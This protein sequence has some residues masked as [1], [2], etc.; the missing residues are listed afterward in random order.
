MTA[1]G[2]LSCVNSH[3]VFKTF[4]NTEGLAAQIAAKFFIPECAIKWLDRQEE[5]VNDFG[6]RVQK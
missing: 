3:M 6:H 2:F 4:F 5:R 1:V